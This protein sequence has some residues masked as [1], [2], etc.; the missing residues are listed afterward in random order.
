M[1]ARLATL[2]VCLVV[3]SCGTPAGDARPQLVVVVD[4]DLP[5]V[6]LVAEDETLALDAA[7]DT[8]RIDVVGRCD[9]LVVVA[10]DPRDWPV[11]F[12]VPREA[13]PGGTVRLRLRLFRGRFAT[14]G[15]DACGKTTLE[16]PAGVT[17]DRGLELELPDEGVRTVLVRLSGD[18][19]G[20]RSNF[21]TGNTC[22]DAAQPNAAL[23]EGVSTIER[24]PL[25]ASRS[26]TW[27]AARETRC[28]RPEDADRI[29]I[30]GGFTLLGDQ[31]LVGYAD[32][33]QYKLDPVP[34]RAVVVSPFLIDRTE[35]TVGRLRALLARPGVTQ[36]LPDARGAPST[37]FR[38]CTWL[39]AANSSSD[40]LPVNCI[41]RA[42]ALEICRA[43]GGTLPS[44][45][46]WEHAARGRGSGRGYP[47]GDQA[48]S[49][50]TAGLARDGVTCPGVGPEASAAHAAVS[51]CP[52][53]DV[54]RDG[55]L[56]LGGNV[57]EQT[58]DRLQPYSAGC[59]AEPG[60]LVD[61]ICEANVDT[62]A[63]R[64]GHWNNTLA[65]ALA[66]LRATG[67]N[68]TSSPT[69][70]FRCTYPGQ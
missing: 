19:W 60:V 41:T 47:W 3:A 5:P 13:A 56:D 38:D 1:S 63:I 16:P 39:G 10:P 34:L 14:K 9:A 46:Q 40:A 25:P 42:R 50:C 26:G 23:S 53:A 24:A 57:A 44:E 62:Y 43:D 65:S 37:R 22:V 58:L 49:C 30:R 15:V 29:C 21:H 55:V 64:G 48:P 7:V 33:V 8:L 51:G 35:Y 31:E 59:W 20:A 17:V 61:P 4:T 67:V 54:S 28:S 70:G 68:V 32:G 27:P 45:A 36:S 69:A 18:C 2:F 12:G 6:G 66:A 52:V 11:S